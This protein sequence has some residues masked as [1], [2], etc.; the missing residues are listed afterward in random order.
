MIF[1]LWIDKDLRTSKIVY[2]GSPFDWWIISLQLQSCPGPLLNHCLCSFGI[3]WSKPQLADSETGEN[4]ICK[5]IY[6]GCDGSVLL[7][8]TASSPAERDAHVNFGLRGVEEVD[9]IKAELESA[10][11]GTVSCADILILAAREATVKVG[12]PWWPVALGRKDGSVSV[13]LLADGNLPFPVLNFSLLVDNFARKN[14]SAREMVVLSGAHTIGK[15]HCNGILPH[16]YNFT[17]ADNANDID[18]AMDKGFAAFLKE[19]CPQGNR[20]NT[21]FLDSTAHRFDRAY[22]K[23]VLAGRGVFITDSALIT[24]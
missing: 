6:L 2:K 9:E 14:F 21:I 8:S 11:P 13:D 18:P 4:G 7:N 15:S 5:S 10:C 19:K 23:N 20:T 1:S 16:L 17:G 3:S 12:G 22:Y 24:E